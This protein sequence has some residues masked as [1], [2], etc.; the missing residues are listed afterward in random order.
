MKARQPCRSIR[1]PAADFRTRAPAVST[2]S[3]SLNRDLLGQRGYPQSAG[4]LWP[5]E[6]GKKEASGRKAAPPRHRF[7]N[8]RTGDSQSSSQRYRPTTRIWKLSGKIG[9]RALLPASAAGAGPYS[10]ASRYTRWFLESTVMVRAPRSVGTF[11]TFWYLPLTSLMMLS[12]PSP[13]LELKAR[14][15]PGANPAPSAPA[16]VGAVAITFNEGISITAIILLSQAAKSFLFLISIARPEG[17]SQGA[18]DAC[19]STDGFAASISMISLE[20]SRFT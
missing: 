15:R 17:D 20:S 12:V 3:V 4:Y 14:P 1:T 7:R 13:P 16:P 11:S 10:A 19:R 18:S 2:L 9:G 6:P 8:R 5:A